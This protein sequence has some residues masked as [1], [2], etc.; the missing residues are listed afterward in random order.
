MTNPDARGRAMALRA[1]VWCCALLL[2]AAGAAKRKAPEKKPEQL[3]GYDAD[4]GA[5]KTIFEI[6]IEGT[7]DLGLAPFVERVVNEATENDVVALRI[8]T[9]G[10]RV[11]G[12]VRIRDALL[13]SKAPTV[14]FVDKRAISAGALISLACDTIIMSEGASM[15]AATPGDAKPRRRDE[16]DL[17]KGGQLHAG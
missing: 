16:G 8:K 2:G 13:E 5:G 15:G 10:G 17:R 9:F 12:A 14:A 11:D 6:P 7:I 3:K 1:S 4:G